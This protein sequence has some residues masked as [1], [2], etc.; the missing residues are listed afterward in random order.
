LRIREEASGWLL[1]PMESSS[2][3]AR[4]NWRKVFAVRKFL[5]LASAQ[6]HQAPAQLV[7]GGR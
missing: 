7:V 3:M 1:A 5:S 6:S 4:V 2:A